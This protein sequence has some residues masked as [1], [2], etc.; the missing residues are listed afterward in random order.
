MTKDTT[1]IVGGKGTQKAIDTRI[2]E[3]KANIT[4]TKSEYD[5]EKLQER[6]AKLTGGVGVIKV[7][8]ASEVEMKEL[9]YVVEDALNA[10]KAAMAEGV[11]AGGASTL[12][13]ISHDLDKLKTD[14]EDEKV[15]ISIVQRAFLAPF[16]AI[17]ENSGMY[18]IS[19]VV[20]QIIKSAKAGF[21]FK[22][23]Q[24]VTDMFKDGIIDPKMVL[25]EAI[26]NASSVA[27]SIITT[28]VVMCDE[29]KEEKATS[30]NPMGGMDY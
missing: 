7:G 18:D 30:P 24:S 16:R 15:G 28:Q 19:V 9:K 13:R 23:M 11:V 21:N 4:Q 17:A 3:I 14:N 6:L 29:P 27:G 8:A 1:T 26:A 20:A 25:R 22:T 5:R 2:N 12:V 10:T